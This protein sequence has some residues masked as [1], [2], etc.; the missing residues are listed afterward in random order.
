MRSTG[1]GCVIVNALAASGESA[2]PCLLVSML[3]DG[4]IAV[5][6]ADRPIWLVCCTLQ[7]EFAACGD[8]MRGLARCTAAGSCGAN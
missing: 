5:F 3:S 4:H 6:R 8:G 7:R 1:M 2:R